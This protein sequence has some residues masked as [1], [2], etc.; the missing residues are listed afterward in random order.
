[1]NRIA[2]KSIIKQPIKKRLWI[3]LRIKEPNSDNALRSLSQRLDFAYDKLRNCVA[4][5][6][7]VL[8]VVYISTFMMTPNVAFNGKKI[9]D[10]IRGLANISPN[11]ICL[12]RTTSHSDFAKVPWLFNQQKQAINYLRKNCYTV[13][14]SRKEFTN[15]AKFVLCFHICFSEGIIHY[16]EFFGS[17]NLTQAGLGKPRNRGNYEEFVENHRPKYSLGN[18][19]LNFLTEIADLVKHKSSLYT[20][21]DYLSQNLQNHVQMLDDALRRTTIMLD[22]DSLSHN[23]GPFFDLYLNT[24]IEYAQTLALL[25]DFP[26]KALTETILDKLIKTHMPI[27]PAELEMTIAEPIFSE[28]IASDLNLT[29]EDLRTR[30]RENISILKQARALII[31]NYMSQVDQIERYFDE[32]EKAFVNYLRENV[33]EQNK[34]LEQAKSFRK[35]V[36]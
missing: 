21:K 33:E 19:D 34:H 13:Q 22:Q 6:H 30:T 36:E 11:C 18:S 1:M 9:L 27:S 16:G 10:Q 3:T 25:D 4:N 12:V 2:A 29:L 24:E 26:G 14:Y 23:V 28:A 17:T 20:N 32:T 8:A 35:T 31:Q 7:D 15:H 5:A